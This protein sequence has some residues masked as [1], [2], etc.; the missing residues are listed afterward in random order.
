MRI[1]GNANVEDGSILRMFDLS[2][3]SAGVAGSNPIDGMD[4]RPVGLLYVV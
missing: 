1:L 4:V 3:W 2:R